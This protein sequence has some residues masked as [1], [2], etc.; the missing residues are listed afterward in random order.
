MTQAAQQALRRIM[1][2]YSHSTRFALACNYSNKII[3]AI[4]SRCAILRYTRLSE[5]E[6][7]MRL[8]QIASAENVP[9]TDDG[10]EAIL[11]TASGDMRQAINNLQSTNAGFEYVNA[12]NVFKVC[13]Q[14]HPMVIQI[15]ID[16]CK[17]GNIRDAQKEMTS[18]LTDKG[19]ALID[20]IGTM[21]KVVK[22]ASSLTEYMKLEFLKEIGFAHKRALEGNDSLIQVSGLLAAL[23][24]V[25]TNSQQ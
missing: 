5:A 24:S 12:E 25:A 13:D 1:E 2:E 22:N 8:Q 4:Q 3:E 17:Q 10:F 6:I 16:Y 20:I 15:I 23:C 7:L 18:E 21:F 19:Y 9:Y 14:P 11:F